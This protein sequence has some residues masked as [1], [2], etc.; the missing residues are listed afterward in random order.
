MALI[1]IVVLLRWMHRIQANV[2]AITIGVDFFQCLSI[3]AAFDL[4]WPPEANAL[5]AYLSIF[6]FNIELLAP[7][8][9]I[10]AKTHNL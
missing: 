2:T 8:C 9:A 4:A 10:G 6:S 1:A 5:F 3:F 7:E